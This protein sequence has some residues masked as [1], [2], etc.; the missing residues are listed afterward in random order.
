MALCLYFRGYKLLDSHRIWL[1]LQFC[2]TCKS[3]KAISTF[4]SIFI[5]NRHNV[6][7][8][9]KSHTKRFYYFI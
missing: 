2:Y 9:S 8:K 3:N 1:Y 6:R 5:V 7:G 4:A